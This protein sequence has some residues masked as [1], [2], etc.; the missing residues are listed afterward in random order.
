M[1]SGTSSSAV[2]LAG[3]GWKDAGNE[4][5]KA[6]A[7]R[8]G[9]GASVSGAVTLSADAA[10]MLSG[11]SGTISHLNTNGHT[12]AKEGTGTL[13]LGSTDI[14]GNLDLKQ[15]TIQFNAGGYA[16]ISSIRMASG[17][18]LK[19]DYNAN[20][21]NGC[22]VSMEDGSSINFWNGTGTSNLKIDLNGNVSLNGNCSGNAA[23]LA[24]TIA[25]TG[26]LNL[27][28]T[29]QNAWTISS[30]ISGDLSLSVNS[31]VTLSGNNSY[32]GGTVIS[33]STLTTRSVSALGTGAVTINGGA[34]ALGGNLEI[35]ALEGTGGSVSL[36]GNLLGI[37]G[38]GASTVYA[39]SVTGAAGSG[40]NVGAGAD[41]ALTGAVTSIFSMTEKMGR[42]M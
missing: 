29:L 6:G 33:G 26:H 21:T 14:V 38:G 40:L 18:A 8:L 36:G 41:L 12:L 9:D 30:S 1:A 7:L 3:A 4:A 20:I 22:A 37:S 2:D 25:G 11:T 15:G 23:V 42:T 5:D 35:S 28:T 27:G 39:G 32:T 13:V 34:L 31:R 16:G 10:L 19:L 17:T 24:G